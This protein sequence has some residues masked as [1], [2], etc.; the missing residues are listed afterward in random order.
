MPHRIYAVVQAME[1][2]PVHEA[3]NRILREPKPTK[4]LRPHHPMLPSRQLRHRRSHRLCLQ[5]V[6]VGTS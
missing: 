3:R 6:V 2:A 1:A 4:L 5:K